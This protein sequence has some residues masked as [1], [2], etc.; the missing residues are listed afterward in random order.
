MVYLLII[1]SIPLVGI[2]SSKVDLNATPIRRILIHLTNITTCLMC[3]SIV[4]PLMKVVAPSFRHGF[5]GIV[6][7]FKAGTHFFKGG[8]NP[9]D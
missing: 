2:N 5:R 3:M 9:Y 6:T 1:P 7:K 4:S 8:L